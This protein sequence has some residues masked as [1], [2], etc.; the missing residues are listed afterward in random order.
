[1]EI[2]GVIACLRKP[3]SLEELAQA[4]AEALENG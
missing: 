4:L 1:L 3:P 2:I